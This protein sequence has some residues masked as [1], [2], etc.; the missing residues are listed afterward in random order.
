MSF[1]DID[2]L[3]ES[4]SHRIAKKVKAYWAARGIIVN[5]RIEQVLSRDGNPIAM[6]GV[7]SDLVMKG[8]R[9]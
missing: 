1:A 2:T 6:W 5:T 9:E 8:P 7:R 3:S 4:G